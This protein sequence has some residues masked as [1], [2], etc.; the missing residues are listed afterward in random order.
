VGCADPHLKPGLPF[1]RVF[2]YLTSSE[3][4]SS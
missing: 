1:E 4:D 2:S 3:G